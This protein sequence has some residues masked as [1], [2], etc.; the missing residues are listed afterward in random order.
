[1]KVSD[2]KLFELYRLMVLT[3]RFDEI[4]EEL[5]QKKEIIGSIHTGVGEEATSVG[6]VGAMG[7]DDVI[8]PSYRD[9]GA[10]FA[11]GIKPVEIAGLLHGKQCG[12][13]H[14]KTR[15]LHAGDLDRGVLPANP[16]LG[17]SSTIGLGAALSFKMDGSDR[18]VVNLFGDGASN[19]GAIHETMNFAA[20]NNLP[21]VFVIVNNHFAWSTP[22]EKILKLP[23]VANRAL[24]YGF[25]GYVVDGN[26]VVDVYTTMQK[27]L[28]E[29][30]N[31]GGPALVECR[32]YRW[33]G[34][35][36]NDK[37]VYR[38]QRER[39]YW[40]QDCPIRKLEGY[41]LEAGIKSEDELEAVRQSVEEEIAQAL[42]FA[43]NDAYPTVE[44]ALSEDV[45]YY[46]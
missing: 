13:S 16:I 15:V 9:V 44:S 36:G 4:E 25:K 33:S 45:L 40:R 37:N 32:T 26:D 18:V 8:A 19:E 3:R 5:L 27:V 1:M 35:S 24:A 2:Q 12:L 34:H 43:K 31:G 23:I 22:T 29:T 41:F 42:D 39:T 17:A 11:K 10:F 28:E 7:K 30:R 21:M 38:E 20:V 14:G 46:M 6:V